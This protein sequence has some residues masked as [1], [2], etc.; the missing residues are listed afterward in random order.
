MDFTKL[1]EFMEH[2]TSWR[3]P[4]NSVSVY[5]KGQEVFK[6]STGFSD[7][8]NKIKMT[9]GELFNIYSCSKAATVVAALQLYERGKFLLDDPVYNYIE[10]FKDMYIEE[11]G[12]L[13]KAEKPITMRHL[14]THTSGI[15]YNVLCDSI[16]DAQKATNGKMP[17][18][19]TVRAIAKE[20]LLFEPGERWSYSLSHDVLAAVVE[21]I[22]G[23][24]FA[25]YVKENIFEPIG[26]NDVYYHIN[27]DISAR[28]AEQYAYKT[29]KADNMDIVGLQISSNDKDG[30]LINT[31]KNNTLVL[32]EEHDSGGAGII[33]S[34]ESYAKFA[35]A[36]A[37]GGM[38]AN[39]ERILAKGTV[40]LLRTNQLS[41]E[42]AVN[43]NW[44]QLKGYGYGLGVRTMINRADAGFNGM[45]GEFGWGG[46]A[47]ATILADP[48]GEVAYFY[49]HHMLNPQEEY[50]QPRLRN[51]VYSCIAD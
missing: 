14:F 10:D 40:E 21:V 41:T 31:G 20:P 47:G 23:T 36:L 24:R 28:M 9:G 19:E 38:A 43:F 5:Y 3:I 39:G 8:E 13:R 37:R 44:S 7:L 50:Y 6:Y 29:G 45:T 33:T 27:E 22:S 18:V 30:F 42:Q 4:G 51:V 48:D 15:S 26:A 34:V 16:K 11:E 49:A 12:R 2:L 35:N 17:T 25:D 32:G 46:A 1:K